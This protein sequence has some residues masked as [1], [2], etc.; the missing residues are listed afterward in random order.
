M[1]RYTPPTARV[2]FEHKI[3]KAWLTVDAELWADE[4]G[5]YKT[6]A[7]NVWLDGVECFDLLTESDICEIESAIEDAWRADRA[8]DIGPD[9]R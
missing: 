7:T 2:Q 9:G 5:V 6:Q 8:D 4:E 3:R 1:N